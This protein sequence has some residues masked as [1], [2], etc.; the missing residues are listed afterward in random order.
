VSQSSS[1]PPAQPQEQP[2]QPTPAAPAKSG[3]GRNEWLLVIFTATTTTAD[4]VTRVALPLLAV[5]LTRSPALVALV[6]VLMMLPWLV[7]ALHVGVFVD[8]SD[9]RTLMVGAEGA[10]MIA[11]A[12]IMLAY[13]ADMVSLPLIYLVAVALGI[14]EV[15]A[16]TAGASIIP[17]AIPK[18]RWQTA[19][20]RITAMEYLCNGFVGAP[21]G[22]FL[23]AA[24]FAIALGTTSIIYVIGMVLLLLLV[25]NF[26]VESTKQRQSVNVEIRDGLVFLWRHTLLRTMALLI[27]VMAGCWAAWMAIIPAYAV[28]GPLQ[29]DERQYGLLLTCLGAGGVVGT[30]VVGPVNRL[31][32]RRWSMFVDILGSLSLVAVPAVVPAMP[33]SAVPIGIAAFLAGIGGTMWTVNARVIYQTLVPND[34]LGRF[35]A[36]SRLVGWG[37][38]PI[39]AAIAGVLATVTNFRIAFGVF[40]VLC[41]ALIIPYLRVVTAQAIAEVDR[42]ESDDEP[43]MP[44][45]AAPA[46]TESAPTGVGQ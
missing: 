16:M 10:R 34:M 13:A 33:A 8:R 6:V 23:V 11:I 43:S 18:A 3:G 1:A 20:A 12:A 24:G 17:S 14:A 37:T 9:R 40:A 25:G 32:G 36:A 42:P 22:G 46:E 30:L 7:T 19:S 26:T 39:A 15:V 29:L 38:T 45:P 2:E 31:L 41:A 44:A 21:I 27:A 4:A 28:G 5:Q 35:S